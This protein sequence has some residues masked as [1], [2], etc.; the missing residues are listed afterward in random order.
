MPQIKQESPS[1]ENRSRH[2]LVRLTPI[3]LYPLFIGDHPKV[4]PSSSRRTK[5]GE[6][7]QS[8]TASAESDKQG[9]G[10]VYVRVMF[11][12]LCT[13]LEKYL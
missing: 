3:L 4:I 5:P 6:V 8:T 13:V 11:C 10:I 1:H 2:H 7:I 9:Y 12:D